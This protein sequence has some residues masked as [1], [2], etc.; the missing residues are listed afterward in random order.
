MADTNNL[1]RSIGIFEFFDSLLKFS[2]WTYFINSMRADLAKLP[3]S[4]R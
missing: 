3:V 1:D 4:M 2:V